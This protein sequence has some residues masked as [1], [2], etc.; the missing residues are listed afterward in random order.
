M[1]NT[2][3]INQL[4][5]IGPEKRIGQIL[6]SYGDG[7]YTVADRLNEHAVIH[8]SHM[9]SVVLKG[10]G[11]VFAVPFVKTCRAVEGLGYKGGCCGHCSEC[12]RKHLA[13]FDFAEMELRIA[14]GLT[15]PSNVCSDDCLKSG[16]RN[17]A[18]GVCRTCG[19]IIKHPGNTVPQQIQLGTHVQIYKPQ[20][21]KNGYLYYNMYGVVVCVNQLTGIC[22]VSIDQPGPKQQKYVMFHFSF[23]RVVS[24]ATITVKVDS[25]RFT[26]QKNVL[27]NLLKL[28]TAPNPLG[29]EY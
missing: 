26:L 6:D 8:E 27:L 16:E 17:A 7:T 5:E 11:R 20:T 22:T 29:G 10:V 25:Q 13:N 1:E 28:L 19:G 12:T 14:A 18:N 24:P 9:T 2:F 4:V 15:V 23:L 21:G 3:K